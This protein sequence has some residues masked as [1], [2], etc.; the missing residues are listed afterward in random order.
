MPGCIYERVGWAVPHWWVLQPSLH[1]PAG[2]NSLSAIPYPSCP[3]G[4]TCSETAGRRSLAFTNRGTETIRLFQGAWFVIASVFIFIVTRQHLHSECTVHIIKSN[5]ARVCPLPRIKEWVVQKIQ[6]GPT[7]E[8]A[9]LEVKGMDAH[10]CLKKRVETQTQAQA[11]AWIILFPSGSEE[12][13]CPLSC[14]PKE[15]SFTHLQVIKGPRALGQTCW[16]S[17]Q[18]ALPKCD[19]VSLCDSWR[20]SQPFCSRE[21]SWEALRA[22]ATRCVGSGFVSWW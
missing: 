8:W 5:R 15:N 20:S 16:D 2:G 6:A 7:C 18:I 10:D 21:N 11:S 14:L 19:S 22:K 12:T 9:G 17:E 4:L 1:S 13:A 3:S